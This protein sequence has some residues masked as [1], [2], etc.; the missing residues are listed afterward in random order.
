VVPPAS[1]VFLGLFDNAAHLSPFADG[2]M[3]VY[4]Q[5]VLFEGG[6]GRRMAIDLHYDT[7]SSPLV[8]ASVQADVA[9]G[10]IPLVSW[11]CGVP[12]S[13]LAAGSAD[14]LIAAQARAVAALGRPVM[15]RWF[16][17]MD[18]S[19]SA[20]GV[21]GTHAAACLGSSGSS[22][23]VAAWRHIVDIF[24]A[25]GAT[26]VAWVF[27]PGQEAY[28]PAASAQGRGASSFYPGDAYVDWIGEDAY[29]RGPAATLPKLIANMSSD[30]GTSGK[31]LIVAETGAV[32]AVQPSFLA[33]FSG[34]SS[35]YPAVKAVVY[36]NSSGPIGSYVLTGSGQSAFD[37]MAR[38]AEFSA[39]PT[40]P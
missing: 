21:Q 19:G 12:D 15:I 35:A 3:Q 13:A 17:E 28:G 1:G 26:N 34:I 14:A 37:R 8:S 20:Y 18:L 11:Q 2:G 38:S 10:R 9:A 31:P 33:S 24:R 27:C 29:A 39:M 32:E 4:D 16:W 22:G 5:L 23:Y 36:F 7:W 40:T 25:N 30:Y 6:V